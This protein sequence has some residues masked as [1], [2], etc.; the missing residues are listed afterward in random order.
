MA[1]KSSN[2]EEN[3]EGFVEVKSRKK[4]KGVASWSFGGL[5]LPKPNSKVIWQQKKSVG[6]KRGSNT[7][8]PSGSTNENDKGDGGKSSPSRAKR[9]LNTSVSNPFEVLNV[10]GKDACDSS[11]QQPKGSDHVGTSSSNL[12]K[13]EAQEEGLWSRFK[14]AN[15]NSKSKVSEL[16]DESDED[17]VYMLYGGGGMDGLEDDLYCYDDYETQVYDQTPQE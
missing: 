3:E 4:N 6:S 7:A 12:D 8:S 14:K 15:E 17:E 5:R 9:A 16:E 1:A 13:K 10:V 11:V 2:M